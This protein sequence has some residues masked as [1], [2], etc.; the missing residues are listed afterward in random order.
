MSQPCPIP[1][2]GLR[3]RGIHLPDDCTPTQIGDVFIIGISRTP[4]ASSNF[5]SMDSR[6]IPQGRRRLGDLRHHV[7]GHRSPVGP[8]ECGV[9]PD[10]P[11]SPASAPDSR[12]RRNREEPS[13]VPAESSATRSAWDRQMAI[14]PDLPGCARYGT[15]GSQASCLTPPRSPRVRRRRGRMQE[16]SRGKRWRRPSRSSRRPWRRF[17]D[18]AGEAAG[19]WSA[20]PLWCSGTSARVTRSTCSHP[21]RQRASGVVMPRRSPMC[22]HV[23]TEEDS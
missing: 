20:T 8:R 6:G 10:A 22:S 12:T 19:G 14:P 3:L 18:E 7:G 4:S 1:C 15:C 9:D 16:R 11:Q 23:P 21:G 5:E 17:A 13:L 2:G